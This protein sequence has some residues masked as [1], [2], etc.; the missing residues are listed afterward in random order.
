MLKVVNN[1]LTIFF[2]CF[3]LYILMDLKTK[4]ANKTFFLQRI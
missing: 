2:I 4:H 1:I 3:S